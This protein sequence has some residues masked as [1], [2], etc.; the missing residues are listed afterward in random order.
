MQPLN[1]AQHSLECRF[2][3]KNYQINGDEDILASATHFNNSHVLTMTLWQDVQW[4]AEWL[5]R[6]DTS[7]PTAMIVNLVSMSYFNAKKLVAKNNFDRIAATKYRK[8]YCQ[9]LHAVKQVQ[10]NVPSWEDDFATEHFKCGHNRHCIEQIRIKCLNH[11]LKLLGKVNHLTD[12]LF[13]LT[14]VSTKMQNV[15]WLNAKRIGKGL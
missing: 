10:R 11:G 13:P 1:D 2:N 15:N 7:P 3:H 9:S 5:N 8:N 14:E 12:C 4:R 6:S